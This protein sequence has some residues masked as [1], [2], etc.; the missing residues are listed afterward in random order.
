[1]SLLTKDGLLKVATTSKEDDA[2]IE[3]DEELSKAKGS[4]MSL[5]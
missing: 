1:M 4:Q 3:L 5:Y 2:N